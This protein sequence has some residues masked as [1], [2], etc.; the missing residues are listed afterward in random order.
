M[1]VHKF[2]FGADVLDRGSCQRSGAT[3]CSQDYKHT[4]NFSFLSAS[5]KNKHFFSSL[6]MTIHFIK[7][8]L[9][10]V[11][12]WSSKKQSSS[13]KPC[14]HRSLNTDGSLAHSVS[15]SSLFSDSHQGISWVQSQHRNHFPNPDLNLKNHAWYCLDSHIPSFLL[16]LPNHIMRNCLKTMPERNS[17]KSI[18][19]FCSGRWVSLVAQMVKNPLAILVYRKNTN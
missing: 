3:G 5:N 12:G 17:G 6:F 14:N 15:G 4:Q 7:Q 13:V 16:H 18:T 10:G 2:S 9:W 1:L 11:S 8:N 19:N